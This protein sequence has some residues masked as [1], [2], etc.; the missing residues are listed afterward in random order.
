VVA[1][2]VND[3]AVDHGLPVE[4]LPSPLLSLTTWPWCPDAETPGHL[5][6]LPP[7]HTSLVTEAG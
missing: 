6:N 4:G 3:R 7:S 2:D 5:A 1:H